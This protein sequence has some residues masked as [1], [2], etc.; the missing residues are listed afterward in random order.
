[1]ICSATK[2]HLF[3]SDC[4]AFFIFSCTLADVCTKLQLG[5]SYV[6]IAGRQIKKIDILIIGAT[7]GCAE[8][9]RIMFLVIFDIIFERRILL[10]C[11]PTWITALNCSCTLPKM[12][13]RRS[14]KNGRGRQLPSHYKTS[15]P[16][17]SS[18]WCASLLV[19]LK[20][21]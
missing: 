19:P 11:R 4:S 18:T 9:V 12:V 7:V 2:L 8:K 15:G 3:P 17:Q 1:M 6:E 16:V 5:E 10:R 14:P 20:V 13:G 21:M